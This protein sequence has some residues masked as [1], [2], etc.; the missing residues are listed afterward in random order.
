MGRRREC[1]SLANRI[2][3]QLQSPSGFLEYE[4]QRVA[5]GMR[6]QACDAKGKEAR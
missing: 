3:I 2:S 4:D 6:L 1:K 5:Q